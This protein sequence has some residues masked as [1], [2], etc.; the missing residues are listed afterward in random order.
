MSHALPRAETKVRILDAAERLFGDRGFAA[1]SLR[2]ITAEARVNLAAV[3]YHFRS[4]EALAMAVLERRMGP[5]NARRMELLDA[6]E[7]KAAGGRLGIEE[8]LDCL[9]RPI[10]EARKVG[11][12]SYFPRFMGRILMEPGGWIERLFQPVMQPVLERFAPVMTRA[13]PGSRPEEVAWGMFFGIG[14][15][16]HSLVA[17]EMLGLV[18]GGTI[19]GTDDEVT[20]RLVRFIAAGMRELASQEESR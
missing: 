19:A 5:L 3:N 7:R 16:A 8:A 17:P 11:E 20:A 15:M 10:F 2:A 14:S 9:V 4:K 12:L 6:A 1:A 18:S 13:L